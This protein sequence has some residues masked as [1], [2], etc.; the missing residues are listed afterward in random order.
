M[1][2]ASPSTRPHLVLQSSDRSRRLG[3]ELLDAGG[4]LVAHLLQLAGL[5]LEV[6]DQGRL[7]CVA[8]IGVVLKEATQ[9]LGGLGVVAQQAVGARVDQRQAVEGMGLTRATGGVVEDLTVGTGGL[10]H[11]AGPVRTVGV[12]VEGDGDTAGDQQCRAQRA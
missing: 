11:V 4:Q 9:E 5:A 1:A 3:A 12:G 8:G 6:E 2:S 7:G 10:L